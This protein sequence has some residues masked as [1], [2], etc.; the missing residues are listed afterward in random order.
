MISRCL[1][2]LALRLVLGAMRCRS[3]Q[4]RFG[5]MPEPPCLLTEQHLP[6]AAQC[7]LSR[8]GQIRATVMCSLLTARLLNIN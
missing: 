2:Y 8:F 4:F 1:G 5:T 3:T 6:G 7:R